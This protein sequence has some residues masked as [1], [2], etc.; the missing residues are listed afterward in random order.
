M[1]KFLLAVVAVAGLSLM[2]PAFADDKEKK[3]ESTEVT[4]VLID[5]ACGD[6]QKDQASAAKHPKGCATKEGCAASGY[7][8]VHGEKHHK[9]DKKG[10][11]LAKEYLAVAENTTEVVVTGTVNDD[12][13]I[14][15]EK[16]E[17]A[18]KESEKEGGKKAEK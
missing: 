18:D 8:V 2:A 13:T 4:G 5:N 14:T 16:I 9:F 12:G 15:V 6:K 3:G 11:E 1:R 7:Q 10:N 17:P